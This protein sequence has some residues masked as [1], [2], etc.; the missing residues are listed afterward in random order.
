MKCCDQQRDVVGPLAQRRHHHAHH[1]EPVVQILAKSARGDLGAQVA[2]G[3]R[4][5]AHRRARV[6]RAAHRPH[7]LLVQRAQ[8]LRLHA[9]R[10]LADLVEE[11][12]AAV[13]LLEGARAIG[14]RAGERAAHVPEQ[15]GLDQLVGDGAAVEHDERAVAARAVA[16]DRLGEQL[17]AGAGLAF[18]QHGGVGGGDVVEHAEQAAQ[19]GIAA[20]QRAEALLVR[21]R[22]VDLFLVGQVLEH[23]LAD[24]HLGAEAPAS[25][26]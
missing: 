7:R 5:H 23:R 21:R 4:D 17:L 18:D 22:Q 1:R 10:Q 8:Q 2:V 3:R 13:G 26:R 11:Q 15:L 19:L 6:R 14:H 20:D 16:V 9:G 25:A 24:R 12:R